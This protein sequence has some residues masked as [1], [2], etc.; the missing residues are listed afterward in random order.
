MAQTAN[1]HESLL[2]RLVEIQ[3]EQRLNELRSQGDPAELL[4]ELMSAAAQ[5]VGRDTNLALSWTR[6]VTELAEEAEEHRVA[7]DARRGQV[8]ALAYAG[9]YQEALAVCGEGVANARRLGLAVEQGRLTLASMHPLTELGRLD[10]AVAA[11]ERAREIFLEAGAE[12]LAARADMNLGVVHQR[13]DRPDESLICLD[14]ALPQAK[15]DP[16]QL[17]ILENSRGEVLVALN[18]FGDAR[19]AFDHALELF[20][21]RGSRVHAAIVESNLADL[22]AREGRLH[23]ALDHFERARHQLERDGTPGHWARLLA[24]QADAKAALGATAEALRDYEAALQELDR[25]GL[26]LEAARARRG[27]GMSLRRLGRSTEAATCLAAAS[28][29]F[30]E[31]NHMTDRATVDLIRSEMMLDLGRPDEASRLALPALAVLEQRPALLAWARLV[32]GR[33]ALKR[34]QAR[35][36]EAELAAAREVAEELD[37]A[38]LLAEIHRSRGDAAALGGELDAAVERY[39]EA[40]SSVERIRGALTVR[41]FRSAF[42]SDRSSIYESLIGA[43]VDQSHEPDADRIFLAMERARSRSL[44]DDLTDPDL[45]RR[46]DTWVI[47]AAEQ[48]LRDE[49]SAL[50]AE[51]NGLYSRLTEQVN[52][53]APPID[54]AWRTR[55]R[56]REEQLNEVEGRLEALHGGRF[57]RGEPWTLE[58]VQRTLD[59]GERLIEYFQAGQSLMA[60]TATCDDVRVCPALGSGADLVNAMNQLRFQIDRVL[61]LSP[62]DRGRL[63]RRSR[64]ANVVLQR[65]H[66]MLIAPMQDSD[67]GCDA[68]RLI[69]VPH[70]PLHLMPFHAI[71]DGERHLIERAEVVTA[72]SASLYAQLTQRESP[73]RIDAEPAVIGVADEKAPHIEAEAKSVADALRCA[74]DRVLLGGAATRSAVARAAARAS[75]LH[76]ACHGRFLPDSPQSSGLRLGDGW[77][78]VRELADWRLNDTVVVLSG[79]ETGLNQVDAGGELTGLTRS[80]LSAGAASVVLSLW[81]VHDESALTAMCMFYE[82]CHTESGG[83][84][85]VEAALRQTQIALIPELVHPAFWAPFL[86]SGLP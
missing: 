38:P 36:A 10:E 21:S 27:M 20:N 16:S 83:R 1:Q 9:Q 32:L 71:Y 14:R 49:A 67:R 76:C 22:S 74:P 56:E 73:R 24:E 51:L 54:R 84:P 53:A 72:P 75:L 35:Q 46:D 81:R 80:L 26:Q 34:R 70:G 23:D 55:L 39:E 17:G 63:Q 64:D 19:I 43:L 69:I 86:V 52:Q 79:C 37:L 31:L 60:V 3:P 29:A 7:L 11:G 68:E 85:S 41:R 47:E 5:A 18:A 6:L 58:A 78:P 57:G 59:P 50:R 12:E 25:R 8:R 45:G 65:L 13:R 28:L 15:D 4:P 2:K 82:Q 62:S 61:H 44:L 40:V 66:E 33:I 77:L 48:K 42:A 30:T